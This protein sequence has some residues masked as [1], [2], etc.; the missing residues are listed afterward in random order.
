MAAD[1]IFRAALTADASARDVEAF[2]EEFGRAFLRL[3]LDALEGPLQCDIAIRAFSDV[4]ISWGHTSSIRGRHS[5]SLSDS[6]DFV[7]IAMLA[8]RLAVQEPGERGIIGPG[9]AM[10]TRTDE[11][12]SFVSGLTR[13][14]N[15]R[16][17]RRLLAPLLVDADDGV[18]R[19]IPADTGALRLLLNYAG[20]LT[21]PTIRLDE[22]TQRLASANLYDLLALALGRARDPRAHQRGV[23]AARLHAAKAEMRERFRDPLDIG[24][25]ARRHGISSS[26]LRQLF[27]AEGSSFADHLLGLRLAAVHRQLRDVRLAARPISALAYEAGFNDLSYFNRCFRRR[28]GMTPSEVREAARLSRP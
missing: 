13:V 24:G 10:L 17:E 1:G 14:V 2:R 3:E 27:A 16:F 6:D 12:N 15:M 22:E 8:G 28:Y 25:V 23:R 4:A 7:L 11:T 19:A 26:Y 20:T 9:E 5:E 18:G 21:D